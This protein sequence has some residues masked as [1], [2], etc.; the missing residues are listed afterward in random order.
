MNEIPTTRRCTGRC[1][2]KIPI[3][4][5]FFASH[6]GGPYGFQCRCRECCNADKRERRRK[7]GKHIDALNRKWVLKNRDKVRANA[8]RYVHSEKGKATYVKYWRFYRYGLTSERYN[9]LLDSQNGVC[10]IC[11]VPPE[12]GKYLHIDHSHYTNAIRG[13]LCGKCNRGIGLFDDDSSKLTK[14]I[15]YLELTEKQANIPLRT[16][17]KSRARKD[18]STNV[19][20]QLRSMGLSFEKIGKICNCSHGTVRKRLLGWPENIAA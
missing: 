14:A 12:I 17:M 15:A 5:E 13:L 1:D 2:R 8:L 3:T 10:A 18:V 16:D 9:S 7:D 6:A 19:L 4:P 20:Q 11:G